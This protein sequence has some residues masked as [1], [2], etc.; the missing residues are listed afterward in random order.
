MFRGGASLG[1]FRDR[2]M[3]RPPFHGG[4]RPFRGGGRYNRGPFRR[5]YRGGSPR[6][7]IDVSHVTTT[8]VGANKEDED[9][10]PTIQCQLPSGDFLI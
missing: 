2:Y 6:T 9:E 1:P 8:P 7:A 4:N 10:K 5:E 3:G